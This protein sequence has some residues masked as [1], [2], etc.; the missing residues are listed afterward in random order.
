MFLA[1]LAEVYSYAEGTEG[2]HLLEM[3]AGYK[4]ILS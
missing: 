4:Y 2:G 3:I 1:Q